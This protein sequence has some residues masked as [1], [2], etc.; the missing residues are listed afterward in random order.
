MPIVPALGDYDEGEIGGMTGRGNR[1][2]WR[3]PAP[4]L[5]C[6]PQTTHASRMPTRAAAGGKPSSNHLNYAT[7]LKYFK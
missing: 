4:V 6:S 5:L 7:A 2:T 3:K 1:I